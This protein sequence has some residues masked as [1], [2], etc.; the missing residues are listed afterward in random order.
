MTFTDLSHFCR[1]CLMPL[2]GS[3]VD[4]A[5][6]DNCELKDTIKMVYNIDVS[7]NFSN[8]CHNNKVCGMILKCPIWTP[9]LFQPSTIRK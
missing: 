1:L 9:S 8:I 4:C 7:A 5:I 3:Y 6:D 2:N